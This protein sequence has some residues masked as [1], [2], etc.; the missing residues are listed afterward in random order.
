MWKH[1]APALLLVCTAC[2]PTFAPPA[3]PFTSSDELLANLL[4]CTGE[5]FFET[6]VA[7]ARVEYYAQGKA[8]KGKLLI[9]AAHPDRLRLEVSSFTDDL[10]SLLLIS[11]EGFTYF[12]RGR[13]QILTGPLCAAPKVSGIPLAED[14]HLL[15]WLLLG[16]LPLMAG[17]RPGEPLTFST[18][19]GTY[20]LELSHQ[21]FKQ[22]IHV[23]SD[24]K[25]LRSVTLEHLGEKILDLSY[26]GRTTARGRTYARRLR[27]T[28]SEQKLDLSLEIRDLRFDVPFRGEPFVFLPPKGTEMH[29]VDCDIRE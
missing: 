13:R 12:E 11:A 21:D 1:A 9:S 25:T 24:G 20:K 7:E 22:I 10:V 3:N 15:I 18:R 29:H 28:A 14:P 26:T 8:R 23:E 2:S 16:R 17:F 19:T 4:V 27:L 6:Y 5:D